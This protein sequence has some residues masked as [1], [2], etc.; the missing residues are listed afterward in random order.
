M[1]S[2]WWVGESVFGRSAAGLIFISKSIESNTLNMKREKELENIKKLFNILCN[3]SKLK[4]LSTQFLD[5]RIEINYI[6]TIVTIM[7]V[8]IPICLKQ[9]T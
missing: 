8:L 4:N 6:L 2:G 3:N 9:N 5:H 7:P 1:K